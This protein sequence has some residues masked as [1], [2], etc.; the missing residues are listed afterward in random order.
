MLEGDQGGAP[1]VKLLP[2]PAHHHAE[3]TEEEQQG[4]GG[5]KDCVVSERPT[6]LK[7]KF[8]Q[9]SFKFDEAQVS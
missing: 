9:W 2:P 5:F 7:P 8:S 3:R 4:A 1:S 6:G